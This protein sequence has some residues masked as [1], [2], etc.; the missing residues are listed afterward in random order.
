MLGAIST[1]YGVASIGGYI[2]FTGTG[3][4]IIQGFADPNI[5]VELASFSASVN[6]GIVHLNWQTATETNNQGFYVESSL[7]RKNWTENGFV[8]G[9][10]QPL[11]CVNTATLFHSTEPGIFI[12]DFVRWILTGH[13]IIQI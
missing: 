8:A 2:W 7:D 13:L 4:E 6:E 5:P 10:G 9:S 12:S 3:G 1:S 11:K